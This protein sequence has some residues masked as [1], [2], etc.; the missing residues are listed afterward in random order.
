[1]ST[2]LD[3]RLTHTPRRIA[4]QGLWQIH[5]WSVKAYT[6]AGT[7]A[8]VA[9]RLLGAAKTIA[10]ET[11][12][13]PGI[14]PHRYGAAFVIVHEA[15]AFNTIAVDWWQNANELNHRFFRAP[16]GAHAFCDITASGESACVW[17]L[18]VQ[19]FERHAWLSHVLLQ[20]RT[21]IDAYLRDSV[22]E[23]A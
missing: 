5:D 15:P 20:G 8:S 11:L 22:D 1:M 19:A 16:A 6:I 17:E 18:R 4:S 21:D 7:G 3:W 2:H 14:A 13:R 23:L 12:P 10:S 9:A